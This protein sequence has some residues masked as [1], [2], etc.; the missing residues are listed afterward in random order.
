LYGEVAVY[1]DIV[2]GKL[3]ETNETDEKLVTGVN[4]QHG[5]NISID[6]YSF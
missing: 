4:E 1:R 2:E 3:L 6:L 5:N